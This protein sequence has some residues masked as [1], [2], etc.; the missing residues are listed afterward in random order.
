VSRAA[1]VAHRAAGALAAV[2]A[3]LVGMSWHAL[4]GVALA[5]LIVVAA[6]CWVLA[7]NGRTRRLALLIHAW[8]GETARPAAVRP[9]NPG[10]RPLNRGTRPNW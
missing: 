8:R 2:P 5:V 3:A 4:A 10:A 9:G 1:G 7:S 6:G